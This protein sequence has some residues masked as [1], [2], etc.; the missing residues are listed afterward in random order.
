MN[1]LPAWNLRLV[2]GGAHCCKPF[3]DITLTAEGP[4]SMPTLWTRICRPLV[5]RFGATP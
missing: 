5:I 4:A 2:C 3:L 1:D